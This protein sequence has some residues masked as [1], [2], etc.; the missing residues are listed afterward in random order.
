MNF[1]KSTG[2]LS[3]YA[4]SENVRWINFNPAHSQVTMDTKT[5]KF[6]G[7]AWAENIGWIHFQNVSPGYYVMREV[8]EP[9]VTT[10]AVT[11]IGSTTATGNGNITDL[12]APDPTEHGVCW[13][14]T[15]TPTTADSKTEEGAASATGAF[16]SS[17]TDLSPNT[18]YYVRAYATNTA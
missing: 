4:W 8:A 14:T 3:G 5:L 15:G 1:D 12:G 18:P 16:T 9:D 2:A 17:M 10:Q 11:D 6:D 13:N 7:Y